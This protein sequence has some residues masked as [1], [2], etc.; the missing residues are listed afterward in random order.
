MSKFT[1]GAK[2]TFPLL[3]GTFLCASINANAQSSPND[4]SPRY[5]DEI[6]T[7]G[8][9]QN[10]A[11]ETDV[12]FAL[13]QP[14]NVS[15]VPR[16][17]FDRRYALTLRDQLALTPG[18]VSQPRFGEDSRL[19]IRGSG[20]AQNIHLR[21]IEIFFEDNPITAADGFGDFQE[22][23]S[24]FISHLTVNR[25]ANAFRSGTTTLGGS[26][27]ISG[28]RAD[29]LE[30]RVNIT[31]EGGAFDTGRGN[32]TVAEDFGRFDALGSISYTNTDGFRTNSQQDSVRGYG[33]FGFQW[34]DKIETRAGFLLNAVRQNLPGSVSLETALTAPETAADL[35]IPNQFARDIDSTR[36]FTKT[37]VDL[38][39]VGIVSFGGTYTDRQLI[40][41][42]GG[43]F[44]DQESE[45]FSLDLGYEGGTQFGTIPVEWS[46]G[47]RYRNGENDALLFLNS[48]GERGFQIGDAVQKAENYQGFAEVR[49]EIIPKLTLIG[50]LNYVRTNRD[51][52][53]NL[54]PDNSDFL[55]Y[56]NF[57]PRG[58]LL[59]EL[60][61]TVD[62]FANIATSYEAPNFFDLNQAGGL[63][64]IP[65]DAQ[66]ALTYEIGTRG[67][68]AGFEFEIALYRSELEDEFIA[69]SAD[70]QI[71]AQ[72]LNAT[73]DTLHQGVEIGA[74][75]RFKVGQS[76]LTVVPRI[77]YT[78]SDLVF[79]NDPEFGD[80]ELPGLPRSA[81]RFDLAFEW[82]RFRIAPNVQFQSDFFV[83]FTNTLEAPGSTIFGIE[84]SFTPSD[85]LE[86]YLDARNIED[87][88]YVAT[89]S[90]VFDAA[91]ANDLDLFTP[92]DGAAVFVGVR[93]GFEGAP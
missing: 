74:A 26:I 89:A 17:S 85:N 75:R 9:A 13:S 67:E 73:G 92:A 69:F 51:F 60:T 16:E 38:D 12:E 14:G 46:T 71:P 5:L 29:R 27:E 4:S 54:N 80:N 88:A 93:L 24:T 90:T 39:E 81:G 91:S 63:G 35:A 52:E 79:D 78:F 87:Q 10:R 7:T 11:L 50:G 56:D 77:N 84:A 31:A 64:F 36:L 42:V 41:P 47:F 19:S 15:V 34:S 40:H 86:F 58:G 30:D 62:L 82:D 66:E 70:P 18:V 55:V 43:V 1:S 8:D 59:Y 49:A 25:G 37:T 72:I 76:G 6:I 61:D 53:D 3:A 22:I 32:L 2:R 83:D 23:D 33:N 48:S 45:E 21:G 65:L 20:L 28:L 57:A 68:Y 44:I